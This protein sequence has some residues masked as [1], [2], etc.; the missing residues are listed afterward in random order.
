MS[1]RTLYRRA[2]RMH[3]LASLRAAATALHSPPPPPPLDETAIMSQD[4]ESFRASL[5]SIAVPS[6]V[7]PTD[8]EHVQC[9]HY[10]GDITAPMSTKVGP[11]ASTCTSLSRASGISCTWCGVWQ[12][13]TAHIKPSD[14][15]TQESLTSFPSGGFC[16]SGLAN[17]SGNEH[18]WQ[19]LRETAESIDINT[20]D[21]VIE[22]QL[23]D[24]RI[25]SSAGKTC[26]SD[27]KLSAL[28]TGS[29]Q[30]LSIVPLPEL[31]YLS[32]CDALGCVAASRH[33]YWICAPLL[34]R[35]VAERGGSVVNAPTLTVACRPAAKPTHTPSSPNEAAGA[36]KVL[37]SPI[38]EPP[39]CNQQ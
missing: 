25:R 18:M 36:Q 17:R 29:F 22:N 31:T 12:P 7:D 10:D 5:F 6:T 9:K 21:S 20:K 23:A 4:L 3:T 28:D 11:S 15:G 38:A 19:P 35:H 14:A 16:D 32:V 30:P 8:M 34:A 27:G 39:A 24:E 33:Y 37:P 1:A 26:G 13:L 2:Q